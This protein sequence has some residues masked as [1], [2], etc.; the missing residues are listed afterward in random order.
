MMLRGS[1]LAL[2]LS[3]FTFVSTSIAVP[4]IQE[5]KLNNGVRV[6]L[7]EAHNVPMVAMKFLGAAHS[8]A[9]K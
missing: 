2:C 9:A 3:L 1:V 5:G 8:G 7:M 6:L 4:P